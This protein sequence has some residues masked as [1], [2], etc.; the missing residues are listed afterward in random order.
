MNRFRYYLPESVQEDEKGGREMINAPIAAGIIRRQMEESLG[1][2][3]PVM[4]RRGAQ[5]RPAPVR[6]ASAG[7]LRRLADRLEPNG[8]RPGAAPDAC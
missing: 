6:T 4:R 2:R 8:T 3:E 7:A 1:L 5:P